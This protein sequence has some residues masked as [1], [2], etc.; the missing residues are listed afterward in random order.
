VY[1]F[2][3]TYI[4]AEPF[5]ATFSGLLRGYFASQSQLHTRIFLNGHLVDDAAWSP[6]DEY[7]FTTT[8]PHTWLREGTN[9]FSVTIPLDMGNSWEA[10]FVNCFAVTYRRTMTTSNDHLFFSSSRPYSSFQ[11]SQ[12]GPLQRPCRHGVKRRRSVSPVTASSA[13]GSPMTGAAADTPR[14]RSEPP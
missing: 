4:A 8:V 10:M 5:S 6:D 12:S 7:A 9:N 11:P 2:S 1:T 14:I 13:Q 3:L